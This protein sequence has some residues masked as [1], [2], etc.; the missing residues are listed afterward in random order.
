MVAG[1]YAMRKHSLVKNGFPAQ[2]KNVSN[3][4]KKKVQSNEYKNSLQHKS[5]GIPFH[6]AVMTYVTYLIH[7]LFGYLRHFMQKY[8][9]QKSRTPKETGNEVGRFS[10]Y[11]FG[12]D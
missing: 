4:E 2:L 10:L 8:G 6:A 3:H 7:I 11:H 9:L 5:E 12:N 1:A